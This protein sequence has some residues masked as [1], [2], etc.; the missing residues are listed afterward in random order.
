MD[1]Q[2]CLKCLLNVDLYTY[3]TD[4][5]LLEVQDKISYPIIRYLGYTCQSYL[6][7]II[8][9]LII[10]DLKNNLTYGFWLKNEFWTLLF[11]HI[12]KILK[13]LNFLCL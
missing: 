8:I 2:F 3:R 1:F 10:F 11:T 4:T 12:P 6:K 5:I 9:N 7:T 13:T